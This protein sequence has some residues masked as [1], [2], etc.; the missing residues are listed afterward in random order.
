MKRPA[1]RLA[2]GISIGL[3]ALLILSSIFAPLIAPYDPLKI[4]MKNRLA[5]ADRLHLLGTDVLGRDVF[6][7]ILYGG[8]MSILLAMA[9]TILAMFTGLVIGVISGYAGGKIDLFITN[10]TCIFQGLPGTSMMIAIS[11]MLG[12]G[13]R[14]LLT[15]LVINSWSGFSR[16]VRGEVI[17]LR[18]ERYIESARSFGAGSFRIVLRYLLPNMAEHIIVLCA[19]RIGSMILSIASLS[20]LGLGIQPPAPD[21][22]VMVSDAR[23]YFRSAP[24]LF[25]APGFCIA[26]VSFGVNYAGEL[27]REYFDV[28]KNARSYD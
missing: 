6:S 7:R 3:L 4:D 10:I 9:A 17:K 13:I 5:H 28:H 18:E 19:T 2:A 25:I 8:R 12:P 23:T 22:G 21:W 14:S 27:L 15:A 24:L 26:V 20:F 11:A 16:I 1:P